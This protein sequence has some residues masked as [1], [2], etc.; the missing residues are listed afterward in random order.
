MNSVQREGLRH[1]IS[2]LRREEI[3]AREGRTCADCLDPLPESA[4]SYQ[5]YCNEA[6]AARAYKDRK[7]AERAQ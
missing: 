2:E 7:R 3:K 4:P 5:R 6:C 1:L